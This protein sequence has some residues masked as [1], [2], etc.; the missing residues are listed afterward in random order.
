M[1]DSVGVTISDCL[2][3]LTSLLCFWLIGPKCVAV[4]QV[5]EAAKS[6]LCIMFLCIFPPHTRKISVP[7]GRIASNPI[8]RL[9]LQGITSPTSPM[10]ASAQ[11]FS[12]CVPLSLLNHRSLNLNHTDTYNLSKNHPHP[13]IKVHSS[14]LFGFLISIQKFAQNKTAPSSTHNS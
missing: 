1:Y 11:S 13:R 2:D 8:N 3:S 5:N 9:D 14:P 4:I 6:Y 7:R 10:S 12:P